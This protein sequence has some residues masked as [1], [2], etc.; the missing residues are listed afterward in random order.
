[1]I[2]NFKTVQKA[3]LRKSVMSHIVYFVFVNEFLIED[4]RGI[5]DN[6]INP[7]VMDEQKTMRN[8]AITCDEYLQLNIY[9][10]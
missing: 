1:M 4:P 7:P 6:F 2:N 3:I 9:I 8:T 5:R 10:R